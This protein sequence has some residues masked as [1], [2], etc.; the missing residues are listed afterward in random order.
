LCRHCVHGLHGYERVCTA[1][2]DPCT[3]LHGHSR[4]RAGI[5][6]RELGVRVPPLLLEMKA[7]QR[8]TRALLLCRGIPLLWFGR[9]VA[10]EIDPLL[11]RLRFLPCDPVQ[12]G[13]RTVILRPPMVGAVYL[14][15]FARYEMAAD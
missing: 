14:P 7:P 9:S 3:A 8:V 2:F 12:A 4:A 6:I 15:M 5:I 13:H 11:Y 10:L 1:V